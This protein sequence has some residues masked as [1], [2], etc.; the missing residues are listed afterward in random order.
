MDAYDKTLYSFIAG[1]IFLMAIFALLV[2]YWKHEEN[3]F[4]LQLQYKSLER[5]ETINDKMPE[6]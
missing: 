1:F 2:I 5:N 6:V 3:M 4:E